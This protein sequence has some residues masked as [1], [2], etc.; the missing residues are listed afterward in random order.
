MTS[1]E[2]V[3]FLSMIYDRLTLSKDPVLVLLC[4][5]SNLFKEIC[6]E[7]LERIKSACSS[8][9][10]REFLQFEKIS[11]PLTEMNS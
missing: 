9:Y 1:G 10:F 6:S 4:S 5:S 2:V 8:A 7:K 11:E 3:N